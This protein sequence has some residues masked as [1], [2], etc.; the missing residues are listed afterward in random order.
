[1]N[2]SFKMVFLVRKTPDGLLHVQNYVGAY[3]G[4]HHVHTESGYREWLKINNMRESDLEVRE[5]KC[6]CGLQPS[7]VQEYDGKVWTSNDF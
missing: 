4:Q 1:M 7:Q 2:M 6:D 5:A 3:R